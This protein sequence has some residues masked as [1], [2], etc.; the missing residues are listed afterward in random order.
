M[1][2]WLLAMAYPHKLAG[3]GEVIKPNDIGYNSSVSIGGD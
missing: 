3:M 2:I 1:L